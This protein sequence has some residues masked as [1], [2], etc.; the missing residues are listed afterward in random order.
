MRGG[1][2]NPGL[3]PIKT[4]VGLK[5]DSKTLDGIIL[6][7]VGT[8]YGHSGELGPTET[9]ALSA[10]ILKN[11]A[12]L[13]QKFVPSPPK[14]EPWYF[15]NV[16]SSRPGYNG[17]FLTPE[18]YPAIKPPWSEMV[19]YDLNS[20]KVVWRK[21]FG[22]YPQLLKKGL[23]TGRE[24]FGAGVITSGGLVFVAAS[25]DSKFRAM[26]KYT[27]EILWEVDIPYSGVATPSVYEVNGKEYVVIACGG[28]GKQETKR[29]DVY[30]CFTLPEK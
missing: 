6:N 23:V 7:G 1:E 10:M 11:E 29:G 22:G 8:M 18:G 30:V 21:A 13:K 12:V 17:K 4:L 5:Y 25:S 24:A 9:T 28:G 15:T 27:G 3:G 26:D 19:A 16:T 2:T 14:K 20:G